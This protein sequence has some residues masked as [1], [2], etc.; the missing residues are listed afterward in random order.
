MFFYL[1]CVKIF[2]F[3]VYCADSF[4]RFFCVAQSFG[5]SR[6]NPT[7]SNLIY[8]TQPLFSSFFAYF[9]LGETLGFYGY[10]GAS[11][12]GIALWIVSSSD[13]K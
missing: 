2:H 1:H 11:M 9:L 13:N 10:V 12:I 4:L 7:D 3:C 5:Q 6:V 8:T